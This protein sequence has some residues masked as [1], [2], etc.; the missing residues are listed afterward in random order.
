MTIAAIPSTGR[1]LVVVTILVAAGGVIAA[2]NAEGMA[3]VWAWRVVV[4]AALVTLAAHVAIAMAVR[5]F[6]RATGPALAFS[7]YVQGEI[8][9]ALIALLVAIAV[10][11]FD[12]VRQRRGW[13]ADSLTSGVHALGAILAIIVFVPY[14]AIQAWVVNA[15]PSALALNADPDAP[16]IV[17]ILLDAYPRA[18]TLRTDY[19]FENGSFLR[20]LESRGFDV[21]SNSQSNYNFTRLTLLSMFS[22]AHIDDLG[23]VGSPADKKWAAW[24]AMEEPAAIQ[25]LRSHGYAV[26]VLQS[27]FDAWSIGSAD[28]VVAGLELNAFETS[29]AVRAATSGPLGA[30][31]RQPLAAQHRARVL[32]TLDALA[33]LPDAAGPELVFAHVL[34]PHPPF[35]FGPDGEARPLQACFPTSCGFWDGWRSQLNRDDFFVASTDQLAFTNGRILRA[36]DRL[37][38]RPD[39]PIVIVFSDHGSRMDPDDPD[40]ML[41]NLFAAYTPGRPALFGED[42]TP[43][44]IFP[45]LLNAYLDEE[46][47]EPPGWQ[48]LVDMREVEQDPF[49]VQRYGQ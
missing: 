35:L 40:E 39:P 28:N 27:D 17:L 14:L 44:S 29:R 19:G 34:L 1:S 8:E 32:G 15:M 22:M 25:R 12:V 41:R 16:D 20:A 31:L 5:S 36:V 4:V 9:L 30:L 26:T 3:L 2:A 37:L 48:Y 23:L 33:N 7:F 49:A 21:A 42:P 11:G 6:V 24:R 38:S 18:D 45:K 10:V 43:I 47:V 46:I 13:S